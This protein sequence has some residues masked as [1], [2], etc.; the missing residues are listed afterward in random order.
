M[1]E[2]N[3]GRRG[4]TSAGMIPIPAELIPENESIIRRED[5]QLI[6]IHC[7]SLNLIP[8]SQNAIDNAIPL[9]IFFETEF[10]LR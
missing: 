3:L 9:I 2:D 4:R 10:K 6:L 5:V 7:K 1:R 8:F